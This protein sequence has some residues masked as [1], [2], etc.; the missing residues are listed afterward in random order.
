MLHD[1]PPQKSSSNLFQRFMPA[2]PT[3]P[4]RKGDAEAIVRELFSH[5]DVQIG[6]TREWDI[7][8]RDARFYE[9]LLRDA[10][11]GFGE[12]YMED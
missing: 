4:T 8:V 2:L 1:T 7:T 3:L 10:S 12:A 9:R 11:V 5:A 6:G